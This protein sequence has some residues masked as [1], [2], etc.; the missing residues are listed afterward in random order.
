MVGKVTS[1]K[2]K[3]RDYT[4]ET[5]AFVSI[6]VLAGSEF[7]EIPGSFRNLIIVELE[8]NSTTGFTIDRYIELKTTFKYTRWNNKWKNLQKRLPWLTRDNRWMD[9]KLI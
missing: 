3:F 9:V 5:W 7:T 8:D 4:M 1:L 6:T 2:H